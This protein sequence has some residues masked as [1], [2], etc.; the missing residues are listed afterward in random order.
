MRWSAKHHAART[1]LR[2]T[3]RVAAVLADIFGITGAMGE[4]ADAM[5]PEETEQRMSN[6][7]RA[8]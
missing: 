1:P 5:C 8:S 7:P 3:E 4:K 6:L 2:E